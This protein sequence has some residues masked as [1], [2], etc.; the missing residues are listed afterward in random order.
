M[1]S[2]MGLRGEGEREVSESRVCMRWER[3]SYWE[4]MGGG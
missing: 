1:V 3:R 2:K 4:D